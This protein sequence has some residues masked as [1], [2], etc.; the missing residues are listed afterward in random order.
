MYNPSINEL[1]NI[2]DSRYTLVMLAAK[3]SRELVEGAEPLIETDSI[4]PVSIAIEEI[5]AKKI[6]YRR[7]EDNITK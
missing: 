4:K 5:V 1:S 3:R 6:S 7:P 2:G